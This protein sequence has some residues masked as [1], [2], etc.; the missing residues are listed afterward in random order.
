MTDNTLQKLKRYFMQ[1]KVEFL[2]DDNELGQKKFYFRKKS[3]KT[4]TSFTNFYHVLVLET[5]YFT[6]LLIGT[7]NTQN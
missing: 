4:I 2:K 5:P 1:F 6:S 7:L 3:I